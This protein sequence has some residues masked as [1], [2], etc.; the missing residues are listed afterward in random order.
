MGKTNPLNDDD[1]KDFVEMRTRTLSEVEGSKG[2][3]GPETEKSWNV[4]IGS[5]GSTSSP[6]DSKRAVAEP[7]EANGF[8][9]SVKNPN[10]PEE[11]P[12]RSPQQILAEMETLDNH[13][14]QLLDSIKELI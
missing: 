11:A 14:Q 7:A 2:Q 9:L 12:L 5:G 10:T 8:D 4:T 1:L 3:Q 6:T 13:T